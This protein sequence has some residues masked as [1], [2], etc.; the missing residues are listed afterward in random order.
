M[1]T[2]SIDAITPWTMRQNS[3]IIYLN[4]SHIR[5]MSE[6][7]FMVVGVSYRI[8]SSLLIPQHQPIFSTLPSVSKLPL[9][10][11]ET[12]LTKTEMYS[13]KSGNLIFRI[14]EKISVGMSQMW[15]A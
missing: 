14:T 6:E 9:N 1:H 8:I 12:I 5:Q 15:K 13:E 2:R 10:M 7:L 3:L 4:H 11:S